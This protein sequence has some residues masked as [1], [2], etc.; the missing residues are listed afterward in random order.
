IR[1]KRRRIARYLERLD[2]VPL[3]RA[4]ALEYESQIMAE[5]TALWQTDEV[6]LKKPTVRDEV[7]MGLDYFPMVLFESLP[8]LY[9][10]LEESLQA[11]YRL[12]AGQA[13]L[14]ELL[15]FGS[16]IGGDRDGNPYVTADSTRDA[17]RTARHVIVDHYVAE[18]TRLVGQLSRSLR[19]I[20]T[21]EA[22]CARVRAYENT[23][24]E[25]HSRW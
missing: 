4:D 6:R 13:R 1:L 18:G 20:G 5:I 19:R 15:Q 9:A 16:W 22:L 25:E 11:V 24:G 7:H 21:S 23:L 8:R 17:L 3:S 10:E 14:P 12:D 2:Q